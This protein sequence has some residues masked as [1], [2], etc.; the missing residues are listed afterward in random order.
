MK[1]SLT[2]NVDSFIK[3]L[4]LGKATVLS[5]SQR[6]NTLKVLV[7]GDVGLHKEWNLIRGGVAMPQSFH[8]TEYGV[9][10]W[11]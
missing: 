9:R 5:V 4:Q 1:Q 3:V 11:P 2:A 6:Q 7:S 10:N 8:A